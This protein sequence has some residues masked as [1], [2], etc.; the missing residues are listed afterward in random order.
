MRHDYHVMLIFLSS[1]YHDNDICFFRRQLD[2]ISKFAIQVNLQRTF[3]DLLLQIAG[4][5]G[6]ERHAVLSFLQKS[7]STLQLRILVH[8]V[9]LSYAFSAVN[10]QHST[11][12]QKGNAMIAAG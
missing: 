11:A 9:M 4:E 8:N 10:S 3:V 6:K 7:C 12:F 5:I 1:Q 2:A